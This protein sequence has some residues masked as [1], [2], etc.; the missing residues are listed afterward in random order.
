MARFPGR[1]KCEKFCH[2]SGC[3]GF[4]GPERFAPFW[5]KEGAL[6]DA[7]P[8]WDSKGPGKCKLLPTGVR[9]EIGVQDS[10]RGEY[11]IAS[12]GGTVE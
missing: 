10:A 11:S 9:S 8:L 1:E 7:N 5:K 6:F 3:H 2:V 12:I 4:F